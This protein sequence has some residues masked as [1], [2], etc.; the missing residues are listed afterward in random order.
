M[1]SDK[2]RLNHIL[3]ALYLNGFTDTGTAEGQVYV[4]DFWT[5]KRFRAKPRQVCRQRDFYRLYEPNRDSY[6]IEK[7]MAKVED[8]IAPVLR[9]V[10]QDGTFRRGNMLG[11]ILALAALIHARSRRTRI[12]WAAFLAPSLQEHLADGRIGEDKW[13]RIR[14]SEIRAGAD[15]NDIPRYAEAMRLASDGD[16]LPPAPYI[17]QVGM[18]GYIQNVIQT[19][20]CKRTW[21]IMMTDPANG[22]FITSDSPLVWGD[23]RDETASLRETDLEVTFPVCKALAL[24]SHPEAGRKRCEATEEVVAHINA[25]TLFYSTHQAYQSADNFLLMRGGFVD[26]GSKYFEHVL[27]GGIP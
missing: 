8:A 21:D 10:I 19:E 26:L 22:G 15:P 14:H 25:R 7:A 11:Y 18:I 3:P 2:P 23:M 17:L 16:W 12:H 13:E 5:P 4:F 27:S 1:S 24:V 20:L 6:E 9:Q